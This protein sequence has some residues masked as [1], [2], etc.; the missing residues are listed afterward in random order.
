MGRDDMSTTIRAMDGRRL[1]DS[2]ADRIAS[3][4]APEALLTERPSLGIPRLCHNA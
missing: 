4:G 3:E 1:I 2:L